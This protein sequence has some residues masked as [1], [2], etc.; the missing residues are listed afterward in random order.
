VWPVCRCHVSWPWTHRHRPQG[1]GSAALKPLD[2]GRPQRA[3]TTTY[4]GR[5]D[6]AGR[7]VARAVRARGPAPKLFGVA[8]FKREILQIFQLKCTNG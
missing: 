2:V 1:L 4:D 8:L 3:S 6:V 7:D 5:V